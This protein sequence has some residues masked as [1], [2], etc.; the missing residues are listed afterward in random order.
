MFYGL[1]IAMIY[2]FPRSRALYVASDRRRILKFV[3]QHKDE[4]RFQK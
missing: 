4:L 1:V 2:D 3:W